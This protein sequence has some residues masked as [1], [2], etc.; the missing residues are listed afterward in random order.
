MELIFIAVCKFPQ[1]ESIRFV[2]SPL[3][4][5]LDVDYF[6][7]PAANTERILTRI[8]AFIIKKKLSADPM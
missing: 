4:P 3:S 7:N 5:P 6:R 8:H 2:S 1:L